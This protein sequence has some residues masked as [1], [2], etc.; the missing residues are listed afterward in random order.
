[1][2]IITF[3]V[4]IV[5]QKMIVN[6]FTTPK[7]SP[8]TRWTKTSCIAI[9]KNSQAPAL[10]IRSKLNNKE[11]TL[12]QMSTTSKNEDTKQEKVLDVTI[13][14]DKLLS[15]SPNEDTIKS[16]GD[17]ALNVSLNDKVLSNSN[18][19]EF[20]RSTKM[21]VGTTFFFV[22]D[23]VLRKIF[24]A[25]GIAFPSMMAGCVLIFTTL[26][27]MEVISK[28]SGD[29]VFEFLTP[30]SDVLVKW[31]PV[32]FVPGFAMLP[33]VNNVGSSIDVLKVFCMIPLGFC[34]TLLSTAYSV[35]GVRYLQGKLGKS[36]VGTSAINAA[37]TNKKRVKPFSQRKCNNL[38][39]GSAFFGTLSILLTKAGLTSHILYTPVM[40]SFMICSTLGAFLFG[41]NLP[42][43][44]TSIIHP[45]GTATSFTWL[46]TALFG[47]LTGSSFASVLQNYRIGSSNLVHA[48][49]GDLLLYM[50]GPGVCSLSISM[51]S[52]KKL[53][54]ENLLAVLVGM[55]V[56][57]TGGI[58][59]SAFYVRFVGIP[60][61]VL[62]LSLITRNVTTAL[63]MALTTI[64]GGNTS[65]IASLLVTTG[66][67]GSTIAR[68][69]M[70]AIKLKDP[71]SR[72]LG[73]G[74]AAQGIGV[75]SLQDEK[76]SLPFAAI[77]MILT[78]LCSS[79]LISTPFV[80]EFVKKI[81]LGGLVSV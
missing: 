71:V 48:G 22:V 37:V 68:K 59:S 52:R 11:S 32:F 81:A 39:F 2:I 15:S 51:Y 14:D 13:D 57:S 73:V 62:R 25:K 54:K 75:A 53:M 36:A 30:S 72:G 33:L 34:F 9:T 23:Y 26:L 12:V 44:I 77:N 66:V 6:G 40:T 16:M 47:Y 55:L 19:K 28:G 49:A 50:L 7:L 63:A 69:L 1:M 60:G 27:L 65:I 61:T 56:S 21:F 8:T 10:T 35:L 29:E 17:L 31:L 42:P 80:R 43:K 41:G 18:K 46:V 3:V 70:N 76:D 79:I 58:L 20:S 24:Q 64:L 38:L 78:A 5:P 45:I 4:A 67:F 74:A